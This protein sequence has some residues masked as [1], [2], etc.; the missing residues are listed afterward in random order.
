MCSTSAYLCSPCLPLKGQHWLRL[1]VWKE[2]DLGEMEGVHAGVGF[3][4][5]SDQLFPH[6]RSVHALLIISFIPSSIHPCMVFLWQY[7]YFF[8]S[9]SVNH[10][11]FHLTP[12]SALANAH[13]IHKAHSVSEPH[14]TRNSGFFHPNHSSMILGPMP[15]MQ[16][17]GVGQHQK[18]NMKDQNPPPVNARLTSPAF[19]GGVALWHGV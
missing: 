16:K 7:T 6:Y 2:H 5:D 18:R 11:R 13:S 14:S 4:G 3:L 8:L 1:R 9:P 12:L 19:P 15:T 10:P 17:H